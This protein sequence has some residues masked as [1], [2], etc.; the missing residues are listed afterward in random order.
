MV[1]IAHCG[2]QGATSSFVAKSANTNPGRV[3]RVLAPLVRA[4]LVA[5]REGGGGGYTLERRP[6]DITLADIFAAV[7]EGPVLPT[8]PRAPN[9]R[10]PIGSGIS[11]ALHELDEDLGVAVRDALSG[12]SLRWLARRVD[13]AAGTSALSRGLSGKRPRQ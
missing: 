6:D 2:A 9:R 5:G 8:H 1:L 4:G 3:R 7:E 12:R 13:A 11:A 10:C